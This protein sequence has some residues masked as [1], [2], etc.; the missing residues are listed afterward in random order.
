MWNQTLLATR[1]Y[2]HY[3]QAEYNSFLWR[4]W[5]KIWRNKELFSPNCGCKSCLGFQDLRGLFLNNEGPEQGTRKG[6][7]E[8]LSTNHNRHNWTIICVI[9]VY[10]G[11]KQCCLFGEL[12]FMVS[13]YYEVLLFKKERLISIFFSCLVFNLKLYP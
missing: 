3:C 5:S 9:K 1:T 10:N 8:N 13:I 12:F 7:A 2:S 6:S 11:Y 4:N